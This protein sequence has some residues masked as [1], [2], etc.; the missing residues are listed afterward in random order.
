MALVKRGGYA[1]HITDVTAYKII[2]DEFSEKEI[3]ELT[4]IEMFPHREQNMVGV[5]Q[6]NSPYRDVFTYG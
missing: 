1:F 6:K 4:E 3:C 5:V 2:R